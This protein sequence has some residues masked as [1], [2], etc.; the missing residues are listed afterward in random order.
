MSHF[1]VKFRRQHVARAAADR[2]IVR[3]LRPTL[4]T[5]GGGV[6]ALE[7][8][9]EGEEGGSKLEGLALEAAD[10][11]A[12]EEVNNECPLLSALCSLPP[13]LCP[14]L[15]ALCSLLSVL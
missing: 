2:E 13:T 7:P 12:I 9:R 11:T 5:Q 10:A 14:L 1:R 8:P 3:V 15:S 4:A 6:S